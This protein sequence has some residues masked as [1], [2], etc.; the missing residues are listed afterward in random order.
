MSTSDLGHLASLIVNRHDTTGGEAL[1]YRRATVVSVQAT[2]PP[3]VTIQLFGSATSIPG[4]RYPRGS[5]PA[6]GDLAECLRAGA[7]LF[8]VAILA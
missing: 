5:A 1:R 4:V 8:I 3:T 6:V 2:T 7:A